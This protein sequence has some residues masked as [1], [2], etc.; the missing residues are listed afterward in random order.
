M[1]DFCQ[2]FS[3]F[4]VRK[5]F[6]KNREKSDQ[7]FDR[8]FEIFRDF[9]DLIFS[10]FFTFLFFIIPNVQPIGGSSLSGP[11]TLSVVP[12]DPWGPTPP[13]HTVTQ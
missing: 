2:I 12:K 13:H 11:E 8:F 7:I 4:F 10:D 5:K 6:R 9:S 1:L 3:T